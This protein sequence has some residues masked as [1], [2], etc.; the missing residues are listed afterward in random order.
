[1]EIDVGDLRIDAQSRYYFVRGMSAYRLGHRDDALHYL[2]VGHQ[3]AL[4]PHGALPA[5]DAEVL[6]RT[7]AELT[8]TD[9][10]YRAR[11]ASSGGSVAGPAN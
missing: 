2:S 4:Q 11:P 10:N 7:L 1:M 9:A 6:E 8:P 5:A 3:T